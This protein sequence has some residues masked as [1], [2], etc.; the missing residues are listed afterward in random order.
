MSV[1]KSTYKCITFVVHWH[2][3]DGL[4]QLKQPVMCLNTTITIFSNGITATRSKCK[5]CYQTPSNYTNGNE[6][7]WRIVEIMRQLPQACATQTGFARRPCLSYLTGI[8]QVIAQQFYRGMLH[9]AQYQIL[10]GLVESRCVQVVL[11]SL[12]EVPKVYAWTL[13]RL[14]LR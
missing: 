14:T 13:Q 3:R 12:V 7:F 5:S 8:R 4:A 10:P 2:L 6:T 9:Q 1:P 11:T